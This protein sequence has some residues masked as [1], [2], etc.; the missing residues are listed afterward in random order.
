M[1]FRI[2]ISCVILAIK[3]NEDDYY[4]NEYY[5][6]VAGVSL[7]EVNAL[8]YECLNMLTHSLFIFSDMYENYEKYLKQYSKWKEM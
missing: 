2:I 5:A 1:E 8:E 7:Q 3:Y 6:K 4:S